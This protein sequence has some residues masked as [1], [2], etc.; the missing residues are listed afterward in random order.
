M[1]MK[2]LIWLLLCSTMLPATTLRLRL[3]L[4]AHCHIMVMD[5]VVIVTIV[6]VAVMV[7]ITRAQ[8][9]IVMATGIMAA[10]IGAIMKAVTIVS[11]LTD[12]HQ[13]IR[14]A[15]LPLKIVN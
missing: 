14:N 6:V 4:N 5:T 7:V 12:G 10:E 15:V 13:A 8:R 2:Q 1:S 3:P 11:I 9:V